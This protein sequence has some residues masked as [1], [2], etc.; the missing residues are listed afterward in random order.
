[1][2]RWLVGSSRISR[3]GSRT[4]AAASST[5]RLDPADSVSSAASRSSARS[6]AAWSMR[7]S[8]SQA[9]SLRVTPQTSCRYVADGAGEV[10]R[11]VLLQARHAQPRL[12]DHLAGVGRERALE[13][14]E[15]R[16]LAGAVAAQQA[17]ALAV[18]DLEAH[19][20]QQGWPGEGEA[21]VVEADQR[22]GLRSP[23]TQGT[24]LEVARL[25]RLLR[26]WCAIRLVL[27]QGCQHVSPADGAGAS[28]QPVP[29]GRVPSAGAGRARF[30]DPRF[31]R[32]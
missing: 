1:M 19:G 11:H 32:K 5:R 15:Q 10:E 8:I 26:A 30:M 7:V 14:L 20:V 28:S 22:H 6:R 4:S 24:M 25:R 17:E 18:L 27:R 12:P 23:R 3:S 13:D 21:H 31:S 16:R 29:T 9:V 2:S